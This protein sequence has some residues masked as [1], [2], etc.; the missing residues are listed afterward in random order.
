M[1]IYA[2]CTW[3]YSTCEKSGSAIVKLRKIH[4]K[5]FWSFM[6]GESLGLKYKPQFLINRTLSHNDN[7]F[8]ESDFDNLIED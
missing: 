5:Y 7:S 8:L 6:W 2:V 1:D 3:K 4:D